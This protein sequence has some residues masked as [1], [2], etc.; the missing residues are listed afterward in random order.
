MNGNNRRASYD[1]IY[2][3]SSGVEKFVGNKSIITNI[4]R[5]QAYNSI[6]HG[7]FCIGFIHSMLTGKSLLDYTNLCSPND[8]EKNDE[9]ILKYFQW[10]K[11]WK[12]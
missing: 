1:V 7:Y 4:H 8:Y 12:N 2:F 10:L 5:M 11:R 6:M 3:D 9:I